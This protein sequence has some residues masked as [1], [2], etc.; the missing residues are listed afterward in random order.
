MYIF[1]IFQLIL[2]NYSHVIFLNII[3]LF[4][5]LKSITQLSKNL[6]PLECY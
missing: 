1:A 3:S 4:K 6:I 2:C 5:D